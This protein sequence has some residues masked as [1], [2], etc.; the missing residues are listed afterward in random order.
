MPGPTL[1]S[2]EKR[3]EITTA[4]IALHAAMSPLLEFLDDRCTLQMSFKV[5]GDK[6]TVKIIPGKQ[7]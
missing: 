5:S 7:G 4:V 3:E 1:H 2:I 6:L